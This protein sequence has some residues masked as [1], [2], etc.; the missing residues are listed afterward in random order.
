[1]DLDCKSLAKKAGAE[2]CFAESSFIKG[3]IDSVR[4]NMNDAIHKQVIINKIRK[5]QL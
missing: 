4:A 5:V 1:M 3:E 2:K